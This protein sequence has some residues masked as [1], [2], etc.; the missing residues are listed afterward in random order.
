[1][2][3]VLKLAT[4]TQSGRQ[5]SGDWQQNYYFLVLAKQKLACFSSRGPRHD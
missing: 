1:M 2:S 4:G 5:K 3:E